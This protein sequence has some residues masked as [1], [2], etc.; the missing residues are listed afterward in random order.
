MKLLDLTQDPPV[1]A[2]GADQIIGAMSGVFQAGAAINV[3][4]A[5]Y[6]CDRWGRKAGF[7]WCAL[8]SLFGGALEVGAVNSTMFIIARLFAGGGSWGFLAV[9]KSNL[10]EWRRNID[11]DN[12]SAILLC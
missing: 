12:E 7:Y 8:L 3:F 6:V 10:M 1:L 9:S 11:T 2:K 5:A 4:I